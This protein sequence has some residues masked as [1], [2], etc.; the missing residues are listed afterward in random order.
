MRDIPYIHVFSSSLILRVPMAQ[1]AKT[2]KI[3]PP[4]MVLKKEEKLK[5]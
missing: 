3:S 1:A 2:E 5:S 4:K